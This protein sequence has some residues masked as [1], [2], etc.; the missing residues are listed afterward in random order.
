MTNKFVF[1]Y[2]VVVLIFP[3]SL[4]ADVNPWKESY[5]L[6]NNYQYQ[7]A[8]NALNGISSD[9]ELVLLRRA[10][11][12]YLK[13]SNSKSIEFYKKA[14]NRNKHSLDARLG[15]ILP[16]LAQQRWREA[17]Q[18]ANKSLE[19]APLNYYAHVRLMITEEALKQWSQLDKHARSVHQYYPSDAT[20]VVYIAR[21]NRKLGNK[22]SATSW[23]KKVLEILPDNVEAKLYLY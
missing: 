14:L 11:L 17:A 19:I 13:G 6:E 22:K 5:R 4:W 7:A 3:I 23:Y 21:A 2:C 16:L 15:I 12:N 9:N 1:L 10:W 20:V 18:N 8:L